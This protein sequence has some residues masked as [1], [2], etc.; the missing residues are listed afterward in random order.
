M[1][2]E[3]TKTYMSYTD[4]LL[5]GLAVSLALPHMLYGSVL[6]AGA[7]ARGMLRNDSHRHVLTMH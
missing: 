2:Q 5:Y 6:G 1:F 4:G 7:A 3:W